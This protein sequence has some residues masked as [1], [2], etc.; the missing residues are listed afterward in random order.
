M[1]RTTASVNP[2]S[3]PPPNEITTGKFPLNLGLIIGA[4]GFVLVLLLIVTY[5][6]YKY[7]ARDDG[8]YKVDESK[9]YIAYQQAATKPPTTDTA[10]LSTAPNAQVVVAPTATK[11]KKDVKEWFV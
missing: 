4:A 1:R 9:N 10:V 11:S 2:A 8:S 5:V 3:E 6:L 7:R